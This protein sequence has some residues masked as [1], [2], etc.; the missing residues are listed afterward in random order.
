MNDGND[1]ASAVPSA[2]SEKTALLCPPTLPASKELQQYGGQAVIEGVMMRSPHYF[3]VACRKPDGTIV[4]KCEEVDKTILGK[5]GRM[6]WLKWPFVRGSFALLDAMALGTRA[7]AYA[8]NVQLQAE[9]SMRSDNQAV[10]NLQ[11]LSPDSAQINADG[12]DGNENRR[13]IEEEVTASA[14]S[15][16][17][18]LPVTTTAKMTRSGRINDI[19]IGGTIIFSLVFAVIL[20]KLLPTLITPALQHFN[21]VRVTAGK[22]G[23]RELNILDGIIRMAI[24]F[25]YIILISQMKQIK[26]VF[27]YHGAEHKAI[28]TLEA[29]LPLSKENALQASRIHPRC[30]TSFIFVVL[31]IDLIVVTFLPRFSFFLARFAL[32]VAIVPIVAGISYELIKFAGKFRRNPLVMAAFAPGMATQ[33]LTTREPD[34]PQT[35]VALAALYS[36]LAAEGHS[37]PQNDF[38][39]NPHA[40]N[41]D[42]PAAAL[43]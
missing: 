15:I 21:I 5:L 18:G 11:H 3:A 29:G 14:A 25:G 12:A 41:P 35:E 26:R 6:R 34:G 17:N 22:T 16:V 7:L 37:I 30:G 20:F 39:S 9:Q 27:M 38:F 36:V 40:S 13:E 43:A 24:F 32:Q 4:V 1:H 33:Y 28:N 8:S 42:E 23:D 19:A 2:V 31:M 10:P